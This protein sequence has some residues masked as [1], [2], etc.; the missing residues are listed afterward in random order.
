MISLN[1]NDRDVTTPTT[2]PTTKA[3]STFTLIDYNTGEDVSSWVEMSV[4]TTDESEEDTPKQIEEEKGDSFTRILNQLYKVMSKTDTMNLEWEQQ[5]IT[6]NMSYLKLI[7]L[8]LI[9]ELKEMHIKFKNLQSESNKR[10][11]DLKDEL[12]LLRN[13]IKEIESARSFKFE[14]PESWIIEE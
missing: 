2:T 7:N 10:N 11:K 13:E 3:T 12:N 5:I 6:D 9:K 4:W 8:F 1:E 14:I